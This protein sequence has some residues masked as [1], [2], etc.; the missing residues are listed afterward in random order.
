M[1]HEPL[2]TIHE[3][4][5]SA[6]ERGFIL[7]CPSGAQL[8]ITETAQMVLTRRW[9]GASFEAIAQ[10]LRDEGFSTA[11]SQELEGY[12]ERLTEKITRLSARSKTRPSS[13]MIRFTLLPQAIV[14]RIAGYFR[15]AYGERI[16]IG[17]ALAIVAC[18]MVWYHALSVIPHPHHYGLGVL[19]QAYGLFLVTLLLHEFGHAAACARFGARP[20]AIGFTLYLTFPALYSDVST[21]W[22]LSRWQRVAVDIG[23]TYFQLVLVAVYMLAYAGSHWLPLRVAVYMAI[24]TALFNLNPLFKFDG[25]WIVAD[26]L[27][28]PNLGQQYRKISRNLL[29]G[30]KREPNDDPLAWPRPLVAAIAIYSLAMVTMWTYFAIALVIAMSWS[31]RKIVVDAGTLM[32]AHHVWTWTD[33]WSIGGSIITLAIGTMVARRLLQRTHGL[34]RG[35]E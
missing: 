23:G 8:R 13:F 16:A 19:S 34:M 11:G 17:A 5:S 32:A 1:I 3:F 12:F 21:A 7:E 24:G 20:G 25:Y 28:I 26:A 22:K 18:C 33:A 31:A 27:G 4:D 10:E 35:T 29:R 9:S 2:G 6:V 15:F 30:I 14:E